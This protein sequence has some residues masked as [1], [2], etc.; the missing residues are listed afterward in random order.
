M[1]DTMWRVSDDE[2]NVDEILD[3]FNIQNVARKFKKGDVDKFGKTRKSSF[4]NLLVS[5]NLNPELNVQE[6][7]NFIKEKAAAFNYLQINNIGNTI[8]FGCV[9]GT[10]DQFMQSVIVSHDLISLLNQ[11]DITLEFSAYPGEEDE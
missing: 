10:Q 9:L 11:Y 6:V 8:D 5:E 3:K 1:L 7:I 2:F 4:F